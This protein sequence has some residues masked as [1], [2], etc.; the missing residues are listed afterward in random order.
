M[1]RTITALTPLVVGWFAGVALAQPSGVSEQ[2]DAVV[3]MAME[4]QRI[5]GLSLAVV[6]DGKKVLT[7]GY[8]SANVELNVAATPETVY[9]I[10]SVTK[11]F[12]ATAS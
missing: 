1:T 9:Q 11:Q 2:V 10:G 5:P 7:K 6:K 8:G 12:T 4:K 3:K